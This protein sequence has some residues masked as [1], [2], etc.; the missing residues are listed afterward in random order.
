MPTHSKANTRRRR[1][2]NTALTHI[3]TAA[4]R[5]AEAPHTGEATTEEVE[6]QLE[7]CILGMAEVVMAEAVTG[8]TRSTGRRA[9]REGLMGAV[10]LVR[11]VVIA[12]MID[13]KGIRGF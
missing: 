1:R 3:P 5:T 4:H 11:I 7:D 10:A 12:M 6:V 8:D 13:G 9:G 2:R